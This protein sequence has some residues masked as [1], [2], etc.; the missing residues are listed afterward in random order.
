MVSGLNLRDRVTF[1]RGSK[2]NWNWKQPFDVVR[3]CIWDTSWGASWKSVFGTSYQEEAEVLRQTQNTPE[4][5]YLLAGLGTPLYSTS[6][7]S[8]WERGLGIAALTAVPV[9][10]HRKS[11][12]L[13]PHAHLDECWAVPCWVVSSLFLL[14]FFGNGNPYWLLSNED[15]F[16]PKNDFVLM[17]WFVMP[18]CAVK[19]IWMTALVVLAKQSFV[20]PFAIFFLAH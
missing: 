3:A 16:L 9:I 6:G 11:V 12:N 18:Y 5:L 7:S 4:R 20:K 14:D 1:G 2:L 8:W 10:L 13:T 17:E 19:E 15:N